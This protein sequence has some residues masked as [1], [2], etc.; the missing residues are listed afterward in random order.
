MQFYPFSCYLIYLRPEYFPRPSV[1]TQ[2]T[3]I[4]WDFCFAASDNEDEA[5]GCQGE[6]TV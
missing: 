4:G 1:S 3:P 5:D 2:L 6:S